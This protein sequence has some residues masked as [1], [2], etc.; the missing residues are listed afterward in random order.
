[1]ELKVIC[2]DE[3]DVTGG[4]HKAWRLPSGAYHRE[5]GPAIE[6]ESGREE[7]FYN[8]SCHRENGP[9]IIDP[10]RNFQCWYQ[11]GKCHRANG[12]AIE[13]KYTPEKDEYYVKGALMTKEE[14]QNWQK[15]HPIFS[16]LSTKFC[17]KEKGEV[18]EVFR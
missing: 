13:Y 10:N 3:C 15:A 14:Y 11:N 6:Y 9:A 7:W 12:P 8:G 18:L 1:M 5:D 16:G 2:T 17:Q 4:A